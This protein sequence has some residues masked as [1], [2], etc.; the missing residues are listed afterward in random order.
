MNEHYDLLIFSEVLAK[1]KKNRFMLDLAIDHDF[2]AV[3]LFGNFF[4]FQSE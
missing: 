3:N 4:F 2:Q 1:K